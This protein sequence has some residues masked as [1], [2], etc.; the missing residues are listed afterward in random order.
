LEKSSSLYPEKQ[1]I[2]NI[3]PLNTEKG[4]FIMSTEHNK[5]IVRRYRQAH[6]TNKLDALDEIIAEDLIPHNLLPGLPAGIEGA[7]MAHQTVL[8]SFPDYMTTTE[9]ELIAENDKVVERWS[10]TATFTGAPYQGTPANG[11]SF[12]VTGISIY[13]LA[14]G[15]IVEHWA[16]ADFLGASQQLGVLPS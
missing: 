11:K 7:K 8:A 15:K 6:T 5:E 16:E 10:C 9:G 13:R 3:Q 1:S 4:A 2:S 14:H 12:S